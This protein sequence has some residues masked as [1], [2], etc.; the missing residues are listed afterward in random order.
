MAYDVRLDHDATSGVAIS[1]LQHCNSFASWRNL[2]TPALQGDHGMHERAAVLQPNQQSGSDL[3]S[4]RFGHARPGSVHPTL[5]L[6]VQNSPE[7]RQQCAIV[8]A[9]RVSLED[10]SG[11]QPHFLEDAYVAAVVSWH[12]SPIRPV[13]WVLRLSLLRAGAQ[14]L[15]GNLSRSVKW[16]MLLTC[17]VDWLCSHMHA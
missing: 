17:G 7:R 9:H 10:T 4:E 3:Q 16:T 5:Q 6:A 8:I 1:I 12:G 11:C 14:T 15:T 13:A 2:P